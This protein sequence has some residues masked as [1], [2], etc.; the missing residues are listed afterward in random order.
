MTL[1]KEMQKRKLVERSNGPFR[2]F[3]ALKDNVTIEP[4]DLTAG[5]RNPRYRNV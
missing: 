4:S 3:V 2:P 1:L 5:G